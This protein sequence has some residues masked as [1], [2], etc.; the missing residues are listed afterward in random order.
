MHGKYFHDWSVG[1][2]FTTA[3]RT[4]TETDVVM[5]AALTGDYNQL[6]TNKDYMKNS[7]FGERIA[8]G[9]LGLAVSHGLFARTGYLEGASIIAFLGLEAWQFKAPIFIGDTISVNIEVVD[10]KLSSSKPDRGVVKFFL[11]IVNQDQTVVQEGYKNI[12]FKLS[13]IK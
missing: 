10:K 5:F 8:H 3:G 2:K 12:L 7:R 1:E 4:I 9:L 13:K 11:Q 6:H